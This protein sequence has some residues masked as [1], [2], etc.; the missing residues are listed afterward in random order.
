MELQNLAAKSFAFYF[1]GKAFILLEL[2]S[3]NKCLIPLNAGFDFCSPGTWTAKE[4]L[5]FKTEN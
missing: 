2:L 5:S 1:K 4:P 3:V